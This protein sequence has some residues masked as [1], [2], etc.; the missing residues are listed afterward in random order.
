M[1]ALDYGPTLGTWML[2]RM[3]DIVK[4]GCGLV[5][6][7]PYPYYAEKEVRRERRSRHESR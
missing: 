4:S 3:G 1:A 5:V 6:V 7:E 2:G